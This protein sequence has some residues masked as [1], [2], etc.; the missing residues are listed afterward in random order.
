M[1]NPLELLA[2]ITGPAFLLVRR[3]WWGVCCA[4][5]WYQ[6]A[7]AGQTVDDKAAFAMGRSQVIATLAAAGKMAFDRIEWAAIG[8]GLALAWHKRAEFLRDAARGI[9][10]DCKRFW[11]WV[12]RRPWDTPTQ[13]LRDYSDTDQRIAMLDEHVPLIGENEQSA[14]LV[15][16]SVIDMERRLDV[17][18]KRLADQTFKSPED[19]VRE[20]T[21][22]RTWLEQYYAT[23]PTAAIENRT[24]TGLLSMTPG[25]QPPRLLGAI[26]GGLSWKLAAA[27]AGLAVLFFGLWRIEDAQ[28][29][30]DEIKLRQAQANEQA[31]TA[32]RKAWVDYAT[33]LRG[34]ITEAK[35]QSETTSKTIEA[36][37]AAVRAAAARERKRQNEIRKVLTGI[38]GPPAWDGLRTQ[39]EAVSGSDGASEAGSGVRTSA[40]VPPDP[41]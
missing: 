25:Y 22:V 28:H 31:L 15:S 37:R 13:G 23:H 18:R 20:Y 30:A 35:L 29:D 17:L 32:N 5:G 38:G 4:A 3:V 27:S 1:T 9:V 26:T 33:G 2:I 16:G 39:G 34:K 36:E 10:R 24:A 11:A 7:Q 41:G 19:E 40:G 14:E 8:A 12:A 6:A 21:Q